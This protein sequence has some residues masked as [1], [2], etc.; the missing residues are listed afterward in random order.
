MRIIPPIPSRGEQLQPA[1]QSRQNDLRR[2][3]SPRLSLQNGRSHRPDERAY[4]SGHRPYQRVQGMVAK[5][6]SGSSFHRKV[7]ANEAK[8]L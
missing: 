8:N 6:T 7:E 1:C 5:I 4:R 2:Q 3:E